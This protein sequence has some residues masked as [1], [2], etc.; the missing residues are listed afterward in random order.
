[1][2]KEYLAKCVVCSHI[3]FIESVISANRYVPAASQQ[4]KPLIHLLLEH[5]LGAAL[6]VTCKSKNKLNICCCFFF[7]IKDFKD[8]IDFRC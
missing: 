5:K 1:M 3:S 7:D 6:S 4:V 2:K 8:F